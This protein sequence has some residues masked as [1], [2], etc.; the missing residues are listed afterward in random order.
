MP[1][2]LSFVADEDDDDEW[3]TNQVLSW[4]DWRHFGRP[5]HDARRDMME[6]GEKNWGTD[7]PTTMATIT[8]AKSFWRRV[9]SSSRSHDKSGTVK[10]FQYK[11]KQATH[12]WKNQEQKITL[13]RTKTALNECLN[14]GSERR[15][16]NGENRVTSIRDSEKWMTAAGLFV[17]VGHDRKYSWLRQFSGSSWD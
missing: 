14:S 12:F 17:V 7:F 16:K 6:N 13:P 2:S 1:K 3:R 8:Y 15:R 9:A 11:K 10:V 5:L 4:H